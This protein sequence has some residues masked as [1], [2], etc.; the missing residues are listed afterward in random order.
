MVVDESMH[1]MR[2]FALICV[3]AAAACTATPEGATTTRDEDGN[4]RL[5][6]SMPRSTWFPADD[7]RGEVALSTIDGRRAKVFGSGASGIITFEFREVGGP[8][9]VGPGSTADCAPHEIPAGGSITEEITK[10]GGWSNDNPGP[11]DAFAKAFLTQDGTHLPVGTW[12]IIAA[13]TFVDGDGCQGQSHELTATIR[14]EVL[15]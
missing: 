2:H 8:R 10:S 14:L 6:F 12:D 13:T 5:Q 11:N 3:L 9:D 15:P 7:I 4:F 1:A